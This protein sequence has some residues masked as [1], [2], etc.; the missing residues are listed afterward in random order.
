MLNERDIIERF[1]AFHTFQKQ[2][3]IGIG[4]D[5]AV[6][7]INDGQSFL[8]T[9]DVLVEDVHF[10]TSYCPPEAIAH[11]AIHSNISDIA[12]MG[13]IPQ[14]MLL[15]LSIPSNQSETWVVH[16]IDA[17]NQVAKAEN[18]ILIGGDTTVSLD[19]LYISITMLGSAHP[20][21]IKYRHTAQVGDIICATGPFGEAHMGFLALENKMDGFEHFKN[22]QLYPRAQRQVGLFLSQFADVHALMDVSDGLY[23]DLQKLCQASKVG[24]VL[25]ILSLPNPSAELKELLR[26]L[27]QNFLMVALEGGEDYGLLFTVSPSYCTKI[28]EDFYTKFQKPIYPLG[29]ITEGNAILFKQGATAISLG[30]KPFTHFG[31]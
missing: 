19:K 9:K 28:A 25:D 29:H 30:L 8:I 23:I 1:A 15:G 2:S 12:A 6:I 16:F 3:H 17:F 27:H 7:P 11:K 14:Y 10:R 21:H 13:G 22:A 26:I 18:I 20:S 4:D 24:A 31:E 5:A